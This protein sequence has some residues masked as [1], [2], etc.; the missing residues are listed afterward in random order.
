MACRQM[1]R[2]SA[3]QFI[4]WLFFYFDRGRTHL[5]NLETRKITSKA[6]FPL[7]SQYLWNEVKFMLK[8]RRNYRK[9]DYRRTALF[10][11]NKLDY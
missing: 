5:F 10:N 7:R 9:F 3:R 11:K 1:V 8:D 6:N 4:N 2:S